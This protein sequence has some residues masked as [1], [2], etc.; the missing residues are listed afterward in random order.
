MVVN[1]FRDRN[2]K[3]GSFLVIFSIAFSKIHKKN[4][5][6]LHF[7]LHWGKKYAILIAA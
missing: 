4:Q 1:L 5:K 6:I 3:N 7:L 2:V